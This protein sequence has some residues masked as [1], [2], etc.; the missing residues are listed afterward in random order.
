MGRQGLGI[1]HLAQ[2]SRS[3]R[4]M[5]ASLG[6]QVPAQK[7][8]RTSS[9]PAAKRTD[10][11]VLRLGVQA[12]DKKEGKPSDA[13]TDL[14]AALAT[15]EADKYAATSA[16]PRSTVERTWL[17]YHA[18]VHRLD[19]SVGQ[20]AFP[21][22][23]RSFKAIAALMK[24][25]GYRS[26]GNYASWAKGRHIEKGYD[27]TQQLAHEHTLAGRSLGRGLGPSR[28]SA[29]FDLEKLA[30]SQGPACRK[31]GTPLFPKGAVILGSLWVLREIE[32]AWT[33][34]GDITIDEDS[35][36]VRW[37]LSASKTDPSAKSCSRKWGCLCKELG[38]P[39]CPFHVMTQYR[40]DVAAHFGKA[41]GDLDPDH[42][43]F[44]DADGNVVL[45]ARMVDALE[46][47]ML[48]IGEPPRDTAGR[49]RFGGHS[50]RVAGSRFWA[51]QGM[52]IYKLQI[53]ARWG[54]DV[55]LRYVADSPLHH[56]SLATSSSA[57]SSSSAAQPRPDAELLQLK[58]KVDKLTTFME[59]AVAEVQALKSELANRD[60]ATGGD[61]VL[62]VSSQCWHKV[63]L[64]DKDV[65][66][67]AWKTHCGWRYANS[68]HERATL[69]PAASRKCDRCFGRDSSAFSESSS[70]GD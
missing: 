19:N 2:S 66:P 38:Q 56:V 15:Y 47:S 7:T 59:D 70:S 31:S 25:D 62:N 5:W 6:V 27:W 44:P 10:A 41:T 42:P 20:A 64:G 65:L 40:E 4:S 57:S 43:A 36:V 67:A 26:F 8:S 61:Y 33:K 24:L 37:T 13:V 63:L 21:V 52:E 58:A 35:Q 60:L 48:A 53:F 9:D 29:T 11:P 1:P 17:D 50:F 45:K 14:E 28:Q 46:A 18:K 51:A 23:V 16:G 22:T 12:A 39:V 69:I 55:I 49:R 3:K 30:H 32:I 34:W 54:S 68:I